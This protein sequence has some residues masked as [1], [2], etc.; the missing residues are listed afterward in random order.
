MSAQSL[1]DA[2]GINLTLGEPRQYYALCPKCSANRKK[3]HQKLKV[4]GVLLKPNGNVCWRCNH[5]DWSGPPK[6][7]RGAKAELP[8]YVYRDIAGVPRFRKVRN[9]PGLKPRFW[10]Q[11]PD[12]SS[13]W[14]TGVQGVDTTILYRVDEIVKAIEAGHK[15]CVVEGEKDADNLW[16]LGIPA[17][18]NAHGA[19]EPNK[20]PKWSARHSIQLKAADIVVLNDNDAPGYAHANTACKQSLGVAKYVRRLDLKPHWPEMSEGQD[21]SDWLALGGGIH[22]KN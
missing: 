8:T 9:H 4:L 1:L 22:L 17:T 16:K 15:I 6:G 2:H 7:S 19:A 3:P 14:K 20:R 12:G 5:C 13:G 10:L 21:V 18:C 11:Q